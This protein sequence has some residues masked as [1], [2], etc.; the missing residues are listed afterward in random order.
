MINQSRLPPANNMKPLH[1]TGPEET[2]LKQTMNGLGIGSSDVGPNESPLEESLLPTQSPG[3][4]GTNSNQN[5]FSKLLELSKIDKAEKP[6]DKNLENDK[7]RK[8]S[9]K[10]SKDDSNEPRK[11]NKNKVKKSIEDSSDEQ[12]LTRLMTLQQPATNPLEEKNTKQSPLLS[13][14]S[15]FK[16][17]TDFGIKKTSLNTDQKELAGKQTLEDTQTISDLMANLDKKLDQ[18]ATSQ[19]TLSST[20]KNPQDAQLA[21]VAGKFD[22][23]KIEFS[24]SE[25]YD[26]SAI[27]SAE[28]SAAKGID[29][30]AQLPRFTEQDWKKNNNIMRDLLNEQSLQDGAMEKIALDRQEH[31]SQIKDLQSKNQQLNGLQLR[32]SSNSPQTQWQ[33]YRELTPD[34][35][36]IVD[37][38]SN[39]QNNKTNLT[40]PEFAANKFNS[41]GRSTDFAT[42]SPNT[43]SATTPLTMNAVAGLSS[44]FTVGGE[45]SKNSANQQG[46]SFQSPSQ[47]GDQN[48]ALSAAPALGGVRGEQKTLSADSLQ[49]EKAEI[50]SRESERT[51]DLARSAALRAQSIASELSIKGGGSAKVQIKDNRLGVVE[52]RINMADNNRVNV[53]VV[54]NNE[55]VR[56]ELEKQID[57]L[58]TGLEKHKVVLEGIKFAT[59]T[60]LGDSPAQNS[61]QND[62]SRN[63]QQ[64][65]FSSFSQNSF[66]TQQQS[67]G[68]GQR[69]RPFDNS[70]QPL[71][72]NTGTISAGRKIYTGKNEQQTNVQR[73]ANGSLK[74]TA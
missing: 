46:S 41:A 42:Q 52:L 39:G 20:A 21:E 53:E 50:N 33:S 43:P 69:E 47:G 67:Q 51:R 28:T 16:N 4:L 1:R 10:F 40:P 73:A 30:R 59:D 36:A 27:N 61:A 72:P 7:P 2:R 14:S 26:I 23:V 3:F 44:A 57:E 63:Q 35:K 25:K 6:A 32:E 37:A 58:R 48:S 62:N 19:K 65:N 64:Q 70:N 38:L 22:D 60:K 11:T 13:D 66:G 54:S 34:Q 15:R 18:L 9:S 74:V 29:Q 17:G 24:P 71:S 45:Q 12:T 68:Q 5:S 49:T 56:K 31:L 55:S 8:E